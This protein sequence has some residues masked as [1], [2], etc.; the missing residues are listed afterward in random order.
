MA[1]LC[2][3][4]IYLLWFFRIVHFAEKCFKGNIVEF[5][6]FFNGL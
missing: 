6:K 1:V 2:D 5:T 3:M 4:V